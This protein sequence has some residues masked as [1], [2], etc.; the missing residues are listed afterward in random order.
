MRRK[1]GRPPKPAGEV[2][3]TPFTIR[4]TEGEKAAFLKAAKKAGRPA[5]EWARSVLLMAAK[6]DGGGRRS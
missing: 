5:S 3:N 6:T 1:P 4:V 2:R